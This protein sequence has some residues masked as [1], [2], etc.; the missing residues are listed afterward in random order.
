[1][2]TNHELS[3]TLNWYAVSKGSSNAY[4]VA[5]P[6]IGF[7]PEGL[8]LHMKAKFAN[9]G[10][11]TLQVNDFD[12]VSIKNPSGNDIA[13]GDIPINSVAHL[14]YDGSQFQLLGISSQSGPTES[15][16]QSGSFWYGV[17]TGTANS[18]AVTLDPVPTLAAGL[19][20]NMKANV[21]N[22]GASTVN[23]NGLGAKSIKRTNGSDL[24]ADDI[25]LDGIAHLV[26]DG[27]NF[28]LIGINAAASGTATFSAVSLETKRRVSLLDA[29]AGLNEHPNDLFAD[30]SKTDTTATTMT[31]AANSGQKDVV[32]A[33]VSGLAVGDS[34]DLL[35]KS[36][37]TKTETAKISSIS[38]LTLTMEDNLTNSYVNDSNLKRSGTRIDSGKIKLPLGALQNLGDGR[39]GVVN[40][41]TTGTKNINT[42]VIGSLRSTNADGIIT[43]VSANPSTTSIQVASSTGFAAGDLALLINLQ[44]IAGDADDVGNYEILEVDSVPDSTHVDV[45]TAATKS[46]DGNTF[47][48]Q[49]VI[50]QRVPQYSS[51]TINHASADLTCKAWDGTSGG[52]VIFACNGTVTVTAG[53]IHAD[54]KGYRGG[55]GNS[56]VCS[57]CF[58][59]QGESTTGT[60]G[61]GQVPNGGAG[62]GG[63]SESP[64]NGDGGGG[65]GAGHG[66]AGSNGDDHSSFPGTAGNGG[67]TLGTANLSS[68]IL[69]GSG[70]GGGK[71]GGSNNIGAGG[72]GG[73]MVAIFSDTISLTG[74]VTANGEDGNVGTSGSG[75]A[76]GGGA[77]GSVLVSCSTLTDNSGN[78]VQAKGGLGGVTSSNQ[79]DGGDA[80]DG[81]IRLEYSTIDGQSF[82]NTTEENAA[83][84]PDPGSS[85]LPPANSNIKAARHRSTVFQKPQRDIESIDMWV[86]QSVTIGQTASTTTSSTTITIT[87]RDKYAVGDHVVIKKS[88]SKYMENADGTIYTPEITAK[89][90]ATTLTVDTAAPEAA[91]GATCQR[92][93]AIPRTS[94]VAKD[95]NESMADMTLQIVEETSVSNQVETTWSYQPVSAGQ[96]V[97]VE[98]GLSTEDTAQQENVFCEQYATNLNYS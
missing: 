16:I 69:L 62:G 41:T 87:D 47:S 33:S 85:S 51:V 70:G 30:T 10:A 73:G 43:T 40:I 96:D 92:M 42:D 65:G 86:R 5:L 6:D 75:G 9:T 83:C 97:T 81:R 45:T 67:N 89:P 53:K 50:L 71:W 7:L 35:D 27:T 11:A 63:K 20:I 56:A 48:N 55:A 68:K 59:T 80:G 91:T 60:G 2:T 93:D 1:M 29:N 84:D 78:V 24:S 28:Q 46:Y 98:I 15:E 17:S 76:G 4:S 18:Y 21:A 31:S 36:D 54:S 37:G 77:G 82:P 23:V 14:V 26:Y 34:V 79:S 58:A 72:I 90:T 44:A 3:N 49:K 61:Q 13:S 32:V 22:T 25:S 88:N 8:I 38:S 19:F 74:T 64:G 66:V 95:A 39:D 52:V 94:I 12:A 57:G